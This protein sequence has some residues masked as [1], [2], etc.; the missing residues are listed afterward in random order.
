LWDAPNAE[1]RCLARI[2]GVRL[3]WLRAEEWVEI[4][5]TMRPSMAYMLAKRKRHGKLL[6]DWDARSGKRVLAWPYHV[7]NAFID[8]P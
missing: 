7:R 2:M 5:G 4:R 8:P 1:L 6:E 3:D